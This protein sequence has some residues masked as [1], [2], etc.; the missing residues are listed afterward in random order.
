MVKRRAAFVI[1]F[2]G[3][4]PCMSESKKGSSIGCTILK[5]AQRKE[6]AALVVQFWI[7][8]KLFNS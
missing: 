1:Q 6:K 7:S 3:N 5:N 4:L 8:I 2:C